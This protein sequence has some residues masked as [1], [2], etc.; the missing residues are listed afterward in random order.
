MSRPVYNYDEKS[1][2]P[3]TGSEESENNMILM[4]VGGLMD[5]TTGRWKLG[6]KGE[7]ILVGGLPP[8]LGVMGRGNVGKTTLMRSLMLRGASRLVE[9]GKKPYIETYD[10]EATH[11]KDRM[12]TLAE[13][14]YPFKGRNLFREGIWKVVDSITVMGEK[15]LKNSVAWWEQKAGKDR[16]KNL[17]ETPILDEDGKPIEMLVPT[18][19]ELDSLSDFMTS[20]IF[21]ILDKSELTDKETKTIYMRLGLHKLRVLLQVCSQAVK[22]NSYV[23]IA[24][25]VGDKIE[26]ATGGP[27]QM[28]QKQMQYMRVQDKMKGVPPKFE[29]LPTVVNQVLT[30]SPAVDG[31]KCSEYPL[32]PDDKEEDSTDL[33]YTNMVCVRSKVG[34][35]GTRFRLLTRQSLGLMFSETEFDYLRNFKAGKDSPIKV[36]DGGF[37]LGKVGYR[38]FCLIYPEGKFSRQELH[39]KIDEDPK[40]E[41]AITITAEILQMRTYARMR[42]LIEYPTIEELYEKLEAEYGWDTLLETRG[43]WTLNQYEHPLP[44][45]STL[46]I[47]RMYHGEYVP[48]WWKGKKDKVTDD[49]KV[50]A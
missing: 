4:N 43:Y 24:A 48:Y 39:M 5:I 20:D 15:W 13:T 34:L 19:H 25:Q 27:P 37:G 33:N 8:T 38:W 2:V 26:M 40:L 36:S 3:E 23:T 11:E 31:N 35:S 21:E 14:N 16:K 18:F 7:M 10:T 50:T 12:N 46:D 28:P 47:L 22:S 42:N 1:A 6:K 44:F 9:A 30:S 17:I 29:F 49:K 41:R 32:H 45:L